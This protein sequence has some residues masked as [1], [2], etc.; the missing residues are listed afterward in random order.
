M[1][2]KSTICSSVISL[3][4]VFKCDTVGRGGVIGIQ[5]EAVF[6]HSAIV[7]FYGSEGS[8]LPHCNIPFI[9]YCKIKIE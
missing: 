6:L 7:T 9:I 1:F 2:K 8:E 5:L 4:N 3:Q